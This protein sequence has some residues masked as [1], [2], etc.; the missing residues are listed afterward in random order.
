MLQH[1]ASSLFLDTPI[2]RKTDFAICAAAARNNA[3]MRSRNH[4]SIAHSKASTALARVNGGV[5]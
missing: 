3:H 1:D 5:S 4:A 2:G